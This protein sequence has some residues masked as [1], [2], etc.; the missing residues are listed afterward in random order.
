M[1]LAVTVA[2]PLL[3]AA[4]TDNGIFNPIQ[5]ASGNYGLTVYAGHSMPAHFTIQPNDPEFG[6]P[7]G[8][9]YDVTSGNLSISSNGTFVETNNYVVTET[10]VGSSN[11]SFTRSGTW[12]ISGTDLTLF[13]PAQ[14]NNPS[15]TLD[16]TLDVD[17]I[18]Y[19]EADAN[20]TLQ[21]YEYKR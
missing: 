15:E 8:G 20:G 14:N 11:Q 13:I 17:T 7:N 1:L 3:F 6:F 9:T 4:C 10:G 18:A 16:A 21:S 19:Q 12:T 5:N 2:T